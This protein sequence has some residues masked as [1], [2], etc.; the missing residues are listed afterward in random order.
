M[1]QR[2]QRVNVTVSHASV[3]RLL[4]KFGD[5]HDKE[6]TEWSDAL[7]QYLTVTEVSE[8]YLKLIKSHS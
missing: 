3:I 2:L 6:V 5:C 8:L 7:K 1:F 4:N